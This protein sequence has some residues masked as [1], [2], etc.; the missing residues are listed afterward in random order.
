[1]LRGSTIPHR[2][3]ILASP[4]LNG[5]LKWSVE[6]IQS[7]SSQLL[8]DFEI[9]IITSNY[10]NK[11]ACISASLSVSYR[12]SKSAIVFHRVG[13]IL[14]QANLCHTIDI[15][16]NSQD[17]WRPETVV[18]SKSA[19]SPNTTCVVKHA[20]I[21]IYKGNKVHWFLSLSFF[22]LWIMLTTPFCR[23][24]VGRSC[25]QCSDIWNASATS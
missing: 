1:M 18:P 11:L 22:G 12:A 10:V 20:L 14:S 2:F 13:F 25:S 21:I 23:L 24:H 17:L 5:A 3:P 4:Q 16:I 19:C 9:A 7:E 8:S 15:Q 6:I